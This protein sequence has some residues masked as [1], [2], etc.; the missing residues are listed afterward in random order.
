M[1]LPLGVCL[2]ALLVTAGPSLPGAEAPAG[3]AAPVTIWQ[4]EQTAHIGGH[5]TTVLGEPRVVTEPDG[6]AMHFNGATDGVFVPVNPLEG[7]SQFTIEALIK[8]E[9]GGPAEQRF[10]HIQDASGSRA[11]LEIRLTDTGW[12]LDTFLR[13]E[14]NGSQCPLLDR[15]KLH[16]AERWTWVALVYAN[17]HMAHYIDGVK[18]LSGD[19][20]FSPMA[21]G[22]ISLGVRQN[23]VYWFKGGI[24]EVRFHAEALT[25]A[26]LQH[27]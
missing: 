17:G 11:L 10:L 23:K 19:V 4:L 20:A 27:P 21:A 7:R 24:R 16:P 3:P 25:P 1:R 8:P 13:S 9:S 5:E 6:P 26:A 15:T 2:V 14:K 22:Q 18:E 12:A